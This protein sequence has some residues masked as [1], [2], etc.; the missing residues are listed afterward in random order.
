MNNRLKIFYKNFEINVFRPVIIQKNI[1]NSILYNNYYKIIFQN[2]KYFYKYKLECCK[3][4]NN[5]GNA[6]KNNKLD[7]NDKSKKEQNNKKNKKT[8]NEKKHGNNDS[9]EFSDDDNEEVNSN[10]S[11]INE[12]FYKNFLE[13]SNISINNV[14]RIGVKPDGNCYMRCVALFIIMRMSISEFVMK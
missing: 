8:N 6:Y 2:I 5:K 12:E 9:S 11:F 7:S 14:D 10:K 1:N 4:K 3:G 13:E